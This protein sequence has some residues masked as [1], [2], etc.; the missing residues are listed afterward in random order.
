MFQK[1]RDTA[2]LES[3]SL[4]ILII[5]WKKP[6]IMTVIIAVI[7]SAIFSGPW[8]ITPKFKSSVVFFPSSTNSISKA[9]LEESNSEKQDILAYGEE[10]QAE[11]MLQILN[12]DEIRETIIKKYNLLD[13][14]KIDQNDP[15]PQSRLFEEFKNNITFSRTEFLSVRI[16]VMDSDPQMAADIANDISSLLDSMKTKIQHERAKEALNIIET[17]YNNKLADLKKKE[18]SLQ[19]LRTLGVIDYSSQAE[20]LS[21]AYT[22]ATSVFENESAMLTVLDKYH[23]QNDSIIVNTKARIKGAEAKMKGLQSQINKITQYGGASISLN[24]EIVY[25]RAELSKLRDKYEKLKLDANQSLT[26][27]F[28][29]NKAVKSERK[30]YPVRWLIILTTTLGAFFIALFVIMSI[31]RYQEIKN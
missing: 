31:Q 21:G 3:T 4:L 9:L 13:H 5:R 25:D 20:I 17:S 14:Y 27:Q 26:H 24:S 11:Q 29:V 1:A 23:S 28:I 22:S 18:D 16:E 8:F 30:A 15:Y 7:A 19:Y 6:L 10:E 2:Y 12:S